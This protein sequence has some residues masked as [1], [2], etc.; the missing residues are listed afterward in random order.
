MPVVVIMRFPLRE[1]ENKENER[2]GDISSAPL[3]C[4]AAGKYAQEELVY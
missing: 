4:D 1:N 2:E 3:G